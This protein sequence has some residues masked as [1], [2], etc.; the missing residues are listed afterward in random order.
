MQCDTA[1]A[2]EMSVLQA[3]TLWPSLISLYVLGSL[4]RCA[5]QSFSSS[6]PE[7]SSPLAQ[8]QE[9]NALHTNCKWRVLGVIQCMNAMW[10]I[11]VL[12]DE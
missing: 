10:A 4:H 6:Q 3:A 5:W 1:S 9:R 2:L 12:C 8:K 7:Q 11:E